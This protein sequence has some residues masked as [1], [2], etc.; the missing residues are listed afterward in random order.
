MNIRPSEIKKIYLE[1]K[2]INAYLKNK[3]G[4]AHNSEKIIELSYDLQAGSY[5]KNILNN[6][7]IKEFY[8]RYTKELTLEINK[9]CNPKSIMEAGI[10]EATTLAN[11]LHNLNN[12]NLQSFGFDISYSR[13]LYAKNYLQKQGC[14]KTK[15]C[16]GNLFDIPLLDDSIDIVYTSH[17]IEPNGGHEKKILK[18]LYRVTNKYLI[19]LEPAYELSNVEIQSRMDHHGYCRNLKQYALELGFKVIKYELFKYNANPLNPTAILIIK[20]D[21]KSN[22]KEEKF[23]C[24]KYKTPLSMY[25]DQAYYSEDSLMMYPIVNEIACLRIENGILATKLL[26][27]N[28][29]NQC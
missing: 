22:I 2:N 23:A 15:L 24:P 5:T 8:T 7:N 28:I 17:S 16:T 10:G 13:L 26:D 25:N 9:L 11:L 4:I 1:G 3:L 12:D 27:H 14:L 20:K 29:E 21:T 19:L 6:D 18:E